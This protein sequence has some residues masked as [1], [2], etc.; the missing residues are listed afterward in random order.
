MVSSI[1]VKILHE[2]D[3]MTLP[4]QQKMSVEDYLVLDSSSKTAHYEYL[5]GEL[6][7]LSGRSVSHATIMENVTS[8]LAQFLSGGL[9]HIYSSDRRLQLSE[10][11][12]VYPD[13]MVSCDQRDQVPG[14]TIHYPRVVF[15]VLSVATEIM[16][17]VKKFAYY[18]ACPTIQEYVMID[19]QKILVEIY[20]REEEEGW[21]YENPGSGDILELRSLHLLIPVRYIYRNITI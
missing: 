18:L 12:Y 10:T 15:E 4:E 6:A 20:H 8:L 9:C 16:D 2:E 7:I 11:R 19:S 3:A 14:S 17:R 13:V 21:E 1:C 5:D